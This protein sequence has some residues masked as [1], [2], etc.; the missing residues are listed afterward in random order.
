MYK[1]C[2][3]CN[4]IN[5]PIFAWLAGD[6][7]CGL[8]KKNLLDPKVGENWKINSKKSQIKAQEIQVESKQKAEKI[9]RHGKDVLSIIFGAIALLWFVV[10]LPAQQ[11]F[12]GIVVGWAIIGVIY[13]VFRLSR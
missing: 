4:E 12:A 1:Q 3:G 10:M 6:N 8:C 5:V 2:W 9:V 11:D 13:L 7:V